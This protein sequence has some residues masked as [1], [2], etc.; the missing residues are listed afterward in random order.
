MLTLGELPISDTNKLMFEVCKNYIEIAKIS[1]LPWV[2]YN[3]RHCVAI[4]T[5]R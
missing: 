2:V 1:M 5:L 4:T 3:M